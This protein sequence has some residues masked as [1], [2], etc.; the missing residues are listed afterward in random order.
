MVDV[1]D[2]PISD[3][4][5]HNNHMQASDPAPVGQTEG[6]RS[7]KT[8]FTTGLDNEEFILILKGGS[9]EERKIIVNVCEI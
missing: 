6:S 1:G 8:R 7:R 3:G 2:C 4:A 5:K 9:M